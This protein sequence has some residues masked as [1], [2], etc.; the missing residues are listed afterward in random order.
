MGEGSCSSPAVDL[1]G[2]E[3]GYEG[4]VARS[5]VGCVDVVEGSSVVGPAGCDVEVGGW[6]HS[7]VDHA[8]RCRV[9]WGWG[10]EEW[11][12]AGGLVPP[13][14]DRVGEGRGGV[15]AFRRGCLGEQPGEEERGDGTAKRCG[16][17]SRAASRPGW[18]PRGTASRTR[19]RRGRG[20]GAELRGGGPSAGIRRGTRRSSARRGGWRTSAT[21]LR[22][23]GP[24]ARRASRAAARSAERT[25]P[26]YRT[27]TPRSL[28]ANRTAA[29][30]RTVRARRRPRRHR[31][32]GSGR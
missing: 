25:R 20:T 15:L 29:R 2:G 17:T 27:L 28:T 32:G 1:S 13:G 5:V 3:V 11:G 6:G 4:S 16:L 9:R 21:G 7:R 8:D 19:R 10:C 23:R 22:A 30:T 24:G 18:S 31:R 26:E 12:Q 14:G